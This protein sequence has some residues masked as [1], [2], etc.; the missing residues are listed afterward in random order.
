MG[1]VLVKLKRGKFY[2]E[3]SDLYGLRNGFWCI[4]CDFNE[5][6]VGGRIIESDD[7]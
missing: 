7:V 4:G 6:G 1:H 5:K 2:Q 3:P